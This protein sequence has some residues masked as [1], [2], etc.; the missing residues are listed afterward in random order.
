MSS[1]RSRFRP[2]FEMLETRRCMAAAVGE[3]VAEPTDGTDEMAIIAKPAEF[4]EVLLIV[5]NGDG[6]DFTPDGRQLVVSIKGG[7]DAD[8]TDAFFSEVGSE[9]S[10]AT[11]T[12]S[13]TIDGLTPG[14]EY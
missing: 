5:N 10:G 4:K 3:L 12:A 11:A 9:D 8:A 7:P 2:R 6:S 13:W 1:K 14:R